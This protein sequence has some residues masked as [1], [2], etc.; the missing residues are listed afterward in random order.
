MGGQEVSVDIAISLVVVAVIT[1]L[2]SRFLRL[3]PKYERKPK[4]RSAWQKLD[5]GD[6]PTV[7]E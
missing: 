5:H 7:D 4:N 6:D 3:S 2:I 1:I